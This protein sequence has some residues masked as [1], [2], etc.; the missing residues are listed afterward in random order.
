MSAMTTSWCGQSIERVEDTALL[1][2]RGR[3]IDDVGEKPGTL[4]AAILP[5]MK[6][7]LWCET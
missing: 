5:R 3:F 6:T 4:H 1:T 2:G 7:G